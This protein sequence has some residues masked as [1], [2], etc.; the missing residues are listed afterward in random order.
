MPPDPRMSL[1]QQL[2]LRA[3]I[4]R[5]WQHPLSGEPDPLGHGTPRPVHAAALCLGRFP[6]RPAGSGPA[7]LCNAAGL[8]RGPGRVPLSVLRRI[9]VDGVHLELRQALEPWHVLGETGAIGGTVRYTDS[10]TERLQVKLT[11]SDPERYTVTCN[12]RMMP[13]CRKPEPT[14]SP[15]PACATRPG[16]RPWPCI[17]SIPSTLR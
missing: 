16:S 11:T 2:L 5:L 8:V 14:G 13:L 10:S 6:R 3:L 1:A 9:E 12:R 7:R 4:A 17:R 15:S